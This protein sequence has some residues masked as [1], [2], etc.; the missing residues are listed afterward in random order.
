M[1]KDQTTKDMKHPH[2]PI[3]VSLSRHA[4][5]ALLVCLT[6]SACST[7]RHLPE[8]EVLYTGVKYIHTQEDESPVSSEL[9]SSINADLSVEPN[10]SF[11]GS[12]R[13]RW[14]FPVGLWAYNAFYTEKTHGFRHW[15]FT[16][17][18]SDP[19]LIS[20][21]NPSLRARATE[22]TL[23]DNGYFG[24][25]VGYQLFPN[26]RNDRKA[27]VGYDVHYMRP[28]RLSKIDYMPTDNEEVNNIVRNAREESALRVG[29]I[30]SATN[31]ETERTRLSN[32]LRGSGYY[33]YNIGN[34]KYLADSTQG[35][36]EIALRIYL[37]EDQTGQET[38]Q[39][40]VIDSV[41][42]TLDNGNGMDPN[43]FDTAGF[44][45]IG[46]R[47]A[48]MRIK[49]SIL[50][51]CIPF[52]RGE[53]YSDRVTSQVKAYMDRL[54]T[55]KYNQV[56]YSL[57]PADS[58]SRADSVNRMLMHVTA[59]YDYPF[60]GQLEFNVIAKDNKQAGP[61]MTV[62]V[63]RRNCFS[64]GELLS[65]EATSSYEWLTGNKSYTEGTGLLNSYEFG[66][67]T[68]LTYPRL[69]LPKAIHVDRDYPVSTTYALAA[70]VMRRS[71]FF[72]MFKGTGEV[73]YDFY[74]D[75]VNSHSFSPLQLSYTSMLGTSARFDSIVASNKVLQQSFSN[76]FIPAIVY[77]YLYDNRKANKTR[78]AQQWL[79]VSVMEA[80]GLLD[81]ITGLFGSR[82]QG[83]RQLLWQRF[84]QFVKGTVDFRNYF[85]LNRQTVLATRLLGGVAYA[86]GNSTVV[87][88]SEQFY[89]GGANSLRGFS[90]RSVGPGR[91]KSGT[92][93]YAYMDQTGDIKL[94][95]NVELRFPFAG[96]LQGAL[97]ADAGNVWTLR[98]EENRPGGT[99][100][101]GHLLD[102]L[103]TDVGLGF[104]YD[105]GILVVRFDV[106]VPLHDPSE[107]TDGKYYNISGSFF[108]NLGYHL[109]VG[110]PF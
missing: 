57:L 81:G 34:I 98:N 102:D 35:N 28:Y 17:L 2:F 5:P 45:T 47:G 80:G 53:V 9:Q 50:R 43:R 37:A 20:Q 39:R 30:F 63:D 78:L 32:L 38:L 79:Q 33:L 59:T 72:Q 1:P 44:C 100:D 21:V 51:G 70:N 92:D 66:L 19:I 10:N 89:I 60:N 26:K 109:A 14:P 91:Y 88:Y 18:K 46:Y 3:L 22:I 82:P 23:E 6:W 15:L 97:F 99:F 24:S 54:N 61:G 8:G 25:E 58:V 75:N 36:H 67:K 103:A 56:Q 101:A 73:R 13:Y 52:Q 7:T 42:I 29:D 94:E 86:Y 106:G 4:V 62:K 71:G 83:E 49:P 68:S 64:G 16:T 108:G 104:R 93:R 85:Q 76:R 41:L 96:D 107:P 48:R 95:G 84:S 87:P 27:R 90:I 12:A 65:F 11:L 74:T 31:L 105:L 40:C 69:Q 55:F 77:T 110:Y